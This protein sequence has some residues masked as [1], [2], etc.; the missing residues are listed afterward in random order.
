LA[1]IVTFRSTAFIVLAPVWCLFCYNASI[2]LTN[3]F[4]K[5]FKHE[6]SLIRNIHG[7]KRSWPGLCGSVSSRNDASA[8]A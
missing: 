2:S 5:H 3:K 4:V 8:L 7:A 6:Y 1:I